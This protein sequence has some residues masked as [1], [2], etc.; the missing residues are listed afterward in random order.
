MQKFILNNE[1]IV[2]IVNGYLPLDQQI[3]IVTGN[4][5][6]TTQSSDDYKAD[7]HSTYRAIIETLV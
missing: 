6:V 3:S 2:E 5:P 7:W 4:S 1:P